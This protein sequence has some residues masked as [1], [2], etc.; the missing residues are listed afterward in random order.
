MGAQNLA[1]RAELHT[2]LHG[3][4]DEL[5]FEGERFSG[6][7]LSERAARFASGLAGLGV[8]PGDRVLV[9]MAN[10]P[11][12]LITYRAAWRAGA[13]VTPLIFLVSEDELK[14][15]LADS[16]AVAVVTTP[17]FL[18]KVGAALAGAP[19]VR[20]VVV[21]GALPPD[22]PSLTVPVLDFA[23]IEAAGPGPI[24]DRADDDLAALLYTGGTTGRSKGVPLS[25][26]NLFWCG[27]ATREV[28]AG[29]GLNR[30]LLPLPLA[31]AYGLLVTCIGL[32]S[33]EPGTT[34]LMRWFDPAGWLDLAQRHRVQSSALVPS[35]IQML[36]AQPL[37]EFDLSALVAVS[38]G[39]A[40]LAADTRQE[41]EKRVPGALI[42]EGYGCTESASIISA[43]PL[44]TRRLGSV[45]K[46]VPGC[47][48]TIL[49]D[50][51]QVLPAGQD[52]EICARSPGVLSGY[53]HAPEA[54]TVALPGD[55]WLHT[56]DI[57]HLDADGYLYV[58]DRKKDLIIR[59]GFNVY[60]RDIEDVL[61]EH[62]A[63]AQ[64]G[65]VGRPDPRL[66]EEVVAFAA[67]RPGATASEGE[68][69]EHAKAHLSATKYPREIRII[70]A[71]PLTSVGKLDRKR[72]RALVRDGDGDGDG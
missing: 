14:H 12:V 5:F 15:A 67:L 41:F 13:A 54:T 23:E 10:C 25:H 20:F 56:G 42:Y 58:V 28:S 66:G 36:L 18:G 24:V 9:L 7:A 30:A 40:P 52:G 43:S 69:I 17:E 50:A 38:S 3:D 21:A 44:D 6:T 63:V 8:Q 64:A 70:P 57:G 29:A 59:G 31:H 60:P 61:L 68:L 55:G 48:V 19:E 51:G 1:R 33:T 72:L 26:A 37:E 45:G 49:D 11:E 27:S 35:M 4:R 32:H 22:R 2:E 46:P 47:E 53:W 16:G 62:P 34:V 65:V 39:A 71:L